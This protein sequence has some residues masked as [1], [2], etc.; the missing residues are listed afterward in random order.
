M[1]MRRQYTTDKEN[2]VDKTI[3]AEVVQKPYG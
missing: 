1:D 3:G 2:A